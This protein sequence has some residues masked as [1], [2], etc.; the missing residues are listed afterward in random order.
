M[1]LENSHKYL[2][3]HQLTGGST[4]PENSPLLD[5]EGEYSL[6]DYLEK[7]SKEIEE[8]S[9]KNKKPGASCWTRPGGTCG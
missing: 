7:L 8:D 2:V 4:S 1:T 3:C 6:W 9:E 5:F